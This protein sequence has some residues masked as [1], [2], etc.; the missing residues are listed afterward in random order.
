M[1]IF[2]LFKRKKN[3]I[4]N[5]VATEQ[6]Q[7]RIPEIKYGGAN[8]SFTMDFEDDEPNFAQDYTNTKLVI[9]SKPLTYAGREVYE[10]DVFWYKDDGCYCA[11][12]NKPMCTL[13][14]KQHILTEIDLPLARMDQE[15]AHV[16]MKDLLKYNRII[17]FIEDGLKDA[18]ENPCG[19]YIGGVKQDETTGE[20][21]EFY[22]DKVGL[23]VHNS[24]S[25]VSRRMEHKIKLQK[26]AEKINAFS[27]M[28]HEKS[29]G[30]AK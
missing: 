6:P 13:I 30:L 25:M 11:D 24:P 12:D 19:N 8:G 17:K 20:Y 27:Q 7:K 21:K 29:S 14:N 2:D 10:C 26:R 15:Y 16:I 9:N 4:S 3:N 18:P 5:M 1:G 23:A 28:H 22:S